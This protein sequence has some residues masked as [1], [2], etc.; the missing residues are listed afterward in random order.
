M[1]AYIIEKEEPFSVRRC[2]K[3]F[4][5][6]GTI[7][8][9]FCG[10]GNGRCIFPSGVIEV[11]DEYIVSCGI[12]DTFNMLIIISKQWL[13]TRLK[14][15]ETFKNTPWRAFFGPIGT[16]PS[17]NPLGVDIEMTRMSG[18]S[19]PKGM[20]KTVDAVTIQALEQDPNYEE[21][22]VQIF[23]DK[24]S[25]LRRDKPA[26]RAPMG[27]FYGGRGGRSRREWES[28]EDM[29]FAPQ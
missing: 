21:I 28:N 3:N 25:S 22:P 26:P 23:D 8:E 9:A 19:T 24:M 6:I 16:V 29:L 1:G 7:E 20:I 13:S 11:G 12:N 15:A 18:K 5:A 4:L 27:V 17:L 2:T 14:P 10:A